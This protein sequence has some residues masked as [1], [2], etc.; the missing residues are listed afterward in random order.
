MDE[1][2]C[3]LSENRSPVVDVGREVNIV[4]PCIANG[5]GYGGTRY[6][7]FAKEIGEKVDCFETSAPWWAIRSE[8]WRTIFA[9]SLW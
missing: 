8:T 1:L 4:N 2:S 6:L 7:V 5:L 3:L 9:Q